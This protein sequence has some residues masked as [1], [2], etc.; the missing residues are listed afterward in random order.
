VAFSPDGQRILTGSADGTAKVW[1]VRNG[2]ELAALA[3]HAGSIRSA[4][5]SSD[6]KRV[7][8]GSADRSAKV[9]DTIRGKELLTL[10]GHT[11]EVVAIGFP[12]QNQFI[13]T[14]S[15]DHTALL[16]HA[17]SPLEVVQWAREEDDASVSL[18]SIRRTRMAKDERERAARQLNTGAIKQWLV[19]AP[20]RLDPHNA[21]AALDK[22]LIPGEAS[23]RPRAGD[24]VST[25][26]GA[27]VWSSLMLEDNVL[28]F[29]DLFP[30]SEHSAAYAVCYLHS[31]T[32][33]SG[34]LMK[35]GSDDQ[36]KVYL[37]GRQIYR[38]DTTRPFVPDAD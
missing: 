31:Q 6:G 26:T 13:L 17:A 5:F 7:V 15:S 22:E 36:A 28:H 37:N 1:D 2:K 3:G 8:T 27:M 34:L 35:V 21:A 11:A 30:E 32:D 10:K 24:R 25:A 18:E 38:Q 19:L 4:A 9:W 12:A 23:L 16:W 33:R 14:G 20:M 29:D